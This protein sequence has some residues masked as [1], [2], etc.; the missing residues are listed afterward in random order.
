MGNHTGGQQLP[1]Y[2]N[3]TPYATGRGSRGGG[4]GRPKNLGQMKTEASQPTGPSSSNFQAK[5]P[6]IPDISNEK[7][8]WEY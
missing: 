7:K 5:M 6:F 4:R 1:L 3:K 8:S 2:D